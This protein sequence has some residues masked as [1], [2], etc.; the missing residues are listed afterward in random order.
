[1]RFDGFV[2]NVGSGPLEIRG[3]PQVAGNVNQYAWTANQGDG[4]RS[5]PGS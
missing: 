1:M 2:T 3:N 4:I 5:D